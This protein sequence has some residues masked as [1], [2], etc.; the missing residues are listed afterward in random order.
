MNPALTEMRHN[1]AIL[2]VEDN[3]DDA[4]LTL[5]ALLKAGILNEVV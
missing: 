4:N 5:R 1:H 3:P 2:L